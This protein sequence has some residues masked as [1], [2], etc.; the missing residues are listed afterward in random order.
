MEDFEKNI[1]DYFQEREIKPSENAWERMEH[2]LNEEKPVSKKQKRTVYWLPIAASV[3]LLIGV[4][5]FFNTKDTTVIDKQPVEKY[6]K[7]DKVDNLVKQPATNN[8][9]NVVPKKVNEALVTSNKK[10][11]LKKST[12]VL[13]EEPQETYVEKTTVPTIKEA[14]E[15]KPRESIAVVEKNKVEI[16][17]NPNKLLRVAEMERQ[18]DNTATG[19]QNFWRKVKEVNT[20]V[21]NYK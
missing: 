2:L 15:S 14:V 10:E 6:V 17:V 21:E 20:V 3:A 4:W 16:Y 13:D 18:I 19:G 1:K 12:I 8:K 5:A 7:V 9:T 11:P